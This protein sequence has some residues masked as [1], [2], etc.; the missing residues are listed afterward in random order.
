MF[1]WG[2]FTTLLNK[3]KAIHVQIPMLTFKLFQ[4]LN[5]QK[6]Q[7]WSCCL[8]TSLLELA[9]QTMGNP[10]RCVAV[11]SFPGS[12]SQHP[13]NSCWTKILQCET[14]SNCMTTSFS[15]NTTKWAS[16]FLVNTYLDMCLAQLEM[17][18]C[19]F[20]SIY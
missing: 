1:A 8:L 13:W 19:S 11:S 10:A 18:Y 12:Y 2:Y 5:S 20:C 15:L 16:V 7:M 6:G 9:A 4:E 14:L 17:L 3:N